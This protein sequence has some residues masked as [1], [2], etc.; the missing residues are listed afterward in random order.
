MVAT[1]GYLDSFDDE[2]DVVLVDNPATM[3]GDDL[4]FVDEVE[5]GEEGAEEERVDLEDLSAK[6]LD[7]LLGPF[8]AKPDEVISGSQRN[9]FLA[10]YFQSTLKEMKRALRGITDDKAFEL[11][12]VLIGK[13]N[14]LDEMTPRNCALV[15]AGYI[16]FLIGTKSIGE[17]DLEESDEGGLMTEV[18]MTVQ[19]EPFVDGSGTEILV[20][21]RDLLEALD[22]A[23]GR[24]RVG[25]RFDE[26]WNPVWEGLQE[27]L[28]QEDL[29]AFV[30]E[31]GKDVTR[32]RA[33]DKIAELRRFLRKDSAFQRVLGA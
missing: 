25:T 15:V 24:F 10:I 18:P 26:V 9:R 13:V 5:D 8:L 22:E 14:S 11:A 6:R 3:S 32:K 28:A 12:T 27:D 1:L 2:P 20:L 30:Q 17:E 19:M 4:V 21:G 23:R 29:I 7:D 16:Q 33:Q 31:G